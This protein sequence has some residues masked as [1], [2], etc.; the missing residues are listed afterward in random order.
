M[1]GSVHETIMN[2]IRPGFDDVARM[3]QRL[4]P[5]RLIVVQSHPNLT[6][7]AGDLTFVPDFV[8]AINSCTNPPSVTMPVFC[9][10]GASQPG[11]ELIQRLRNV[12]R[13]HPDAVMILMADIKEARPYSSPAYRSVAYRTL[14]RETSVRSQGS[15]L[16]LRTGARSL[17]RP[18]KV[19][20]EGHCWCDLS[21]VDFQVWIRGS[22]PID[23]D[24]DNL[25]LTARGVSTISSS[26]FVTYA[27]SRHYFHIK[28]WTT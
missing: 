3:L 5:G 14:R 7:R 2:V 19:V 15:F 25:Q 6:I 4:I 20:V 18:T 13:A 11:T 28:G 12:A 27:N 22:T 16:S 23:I 24:T 1:P 8:H 9:E 21:A 17:N 26:P 10:I